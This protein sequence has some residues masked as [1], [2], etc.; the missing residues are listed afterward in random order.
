MWFSF[1]VILKAVSPLYLIVYNPRLGHSCIPPAA[2]AAPLQG[3]T[4]TERSLRSTQPWQRCSPVCHASLVA[5][6]RSA[7]LWSGLTLP[8]QC[9]SD[10]V[11]AE[12]NISRW[13]RRASAAA[14]GDNLKPTRWQI[15]LEIYS[16]LFTLRIHIVMIQCD[17]Q[18]R[19]LW[20]QTPG[21][22]QHIDTCLKA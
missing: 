12:V 16:T 6:L 3:L 11:S 19:H 9:F 21:A 14:S 17:K 20:H 2:A 15:N 4:L 18:H 8:A 10:T 1:P 22:G 13:L 7:N 5:S